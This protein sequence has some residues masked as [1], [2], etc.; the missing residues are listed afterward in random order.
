[1]SKLLFLVL[2]VVFFTPCIWANDVEN[3]QKIITQFKIVNI[4]SINKDVVNYQIVN[5]PYEFKQ[6]VVSDYTI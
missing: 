6:Q 4:R 1:M 3:L 2:T 5:N